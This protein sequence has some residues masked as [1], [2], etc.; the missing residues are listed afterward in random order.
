[1]KEYIRTSFENTAF[2]EKE[3]AESSTINDPKQYMH[4]NVQ[5]YEKLDA[6]F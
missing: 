2:T 4:E 1:M 5:V 3:M 6:Y